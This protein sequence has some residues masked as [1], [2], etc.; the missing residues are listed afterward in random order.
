MYICHLGTAC[1]Q[2]FNTTGAHQTPLAPSVCSTVQQ[3]GAT[4]SICI[5]AL[6]Q[7]HAHTP[8]PNLSSQLHLQALHTHGKQA[9]QLV[10]PPQHSHSVAHSL[11]V[12]QLPRVLT[13]V[14]T[15]P[16]H[17]AAVAVLLLVTRPQQ[18]RDYA[19]ISAACA[20]ATRLPKHCH[21]TK[22][23]RLRS[24]L[25]RVSTTGHL[26]KPHTHRLNQPRNPVRCT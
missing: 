18:G 17:T 16:R 14:L 12:L 5:P 20:C 7:Q 25:E 13:T 11:H 24:T 15:K 19:G 3:S 9:K 2:Q 26:R 23:L 21:S 6:Q 4:V 8:T 1:T 22:L 10:T